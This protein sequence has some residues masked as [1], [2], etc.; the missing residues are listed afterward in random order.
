MGF[1]RRYIFPRLM[2]RLVSSEQVQKLRAETLEPA[3]GEVLEV[4]FGTGQNLAHYPE[5]VTRI[6]GIEPNPGMASVAAKR[7]DG[8]RLPVDVHHAS[9][10]ALSFPDQSFDTIVTTLTLCSIEDV[11]RA[12]VEMR[13][14][15]RPS[16]ALLVLEHGLSTEQ[17]VQKWQRRFNGINR[18]LADGCRLDRNI[19]GLVE[20]AGF[21]FDALRTFYMEGEPRATGFMTLGSAAPRTQ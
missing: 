11:E 2:D 6:V 13:R 4:G 15:L 16:G 8:S 19:A 3:R 7:L 9:A 12:L 17:S 18:R 1:Y 5:A 14:V 21:A 10:E 20:D